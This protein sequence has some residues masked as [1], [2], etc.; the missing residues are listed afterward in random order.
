MQ[1]LSVIGLLFCVFL[2]AV[3]LTGAIR[4]YAI[5]REILD[6][7]NARSSHTVSTPRGGGAAI[8]IA[9]SAGVVIVW[10]F[11]GIETEVA[12]AV[13][14]AG[15]LVAGIGLWDD[16]G[17]IPLKLRLLVHFAAAFW[18]LYWLGGAPPLQLFGFFF[19]AGWLSVGLGAVFLVW[20]LNLFNFMDG[21]DGIAGSVAVFIAAGGALLAWFAGLEDLA[22]ISSLL[23]MATL[24]FLIWNWPPAK[25]FMGD[26]GSG[27][28]GVVLGILA[29]A[30]AGE[31]AVSLWSWLIL[32]G[33]FLVDATITLFRRMLR[34]ER[35]YEAHC[36]HAYQWS[37]RRWGHLKVTIAVNLVNCCWLF[38]MAYTAF[39]YPE[40][41]AV[42]AL[43]TLVPLILVA[44]KLGAGLPE[45]ASQ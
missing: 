22:I 41:G 14:G 38:P 36:S 11:R 13:T 8:V 29:Y 18:A 19:Q 31:G 33:V 6:V 42:I 21:I 3:L 2:C 44:L 7:P 5:A 15:L 26:A 9:F 1:A 16:H 24:G 20:L 32:F 37:A 39:L 27:F 45:E 35:W 23:A 34:G 25:I 28:L 30:G 10:A 12:L 4:R 43:A 17:H 40:W